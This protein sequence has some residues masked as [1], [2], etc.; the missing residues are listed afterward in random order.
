MTAG[1]EYNI[2]KP[3]GCSMETSATKYHPH[4]FFQER[5]SLRHALVFLEAHIE[6]IRNVK[7]WAADMGYSRCYFS[8]TI[9][10]IYGETA[11]SLLH[12]VRLAALCDA[13]SYHPDKK[14]YSIA[15]ETGFNNDKMMGQFLSRNFHI[16]IADMRKKAEVGFDELEMIKMSKEEI[17]CYFKNRTETDCK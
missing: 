2:M 4:S 1:Y 8:R 5:K 9:H 15:Q 16:V 17:Y 12:K 10:D 7:Q 13:W 3:N 6:T 14:A 11:I